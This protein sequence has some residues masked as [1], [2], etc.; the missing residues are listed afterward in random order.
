MSYAIGWPKEQGGDRDRPIDERHDTWVRIFN[1]PAEG[2]LAARCMPE[3]DLEVGQ[4]LRVKLVS[5]EVERGLMDIV[6]GD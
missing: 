4:Q 5:A 1:P 6:L 3:L 2:R